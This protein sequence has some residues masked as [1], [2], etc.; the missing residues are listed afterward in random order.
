[1]LYNTLSKKYHVTLGLAINAYLTSNN[2]GFDEK[3][4]C[5]LNIMDYCCRLAF[6]KFI[7]GKNKNKNNKDTSEYKSHLFIGSGASFEQIKAMEHVEH[8]GNELANGEYVYFTFVPNVGP[9]KI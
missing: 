7:V 4:C 1:M 5:S 2:G 6:D 8:V 3:E 9:C